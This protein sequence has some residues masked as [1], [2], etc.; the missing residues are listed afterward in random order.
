[1]NEIILLILIGLAAGMLGGLFGVGGGIIVIPA[2]IYL[3]GMTQH[4]AQG[5]SVAFMLLP[6]GLLAFINYYKNGYIN[7]KFAAIL[8]AAF[9][10][11]AFFGSKI[12]IN[13]SSDTLKKM[14]AVLVIITGIKLFFD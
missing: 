3:L 12:A 6:V 13:L 7:I 8:A 14:F 11:G 5:T 9:F 2:L 4:Q 10:V 1:M